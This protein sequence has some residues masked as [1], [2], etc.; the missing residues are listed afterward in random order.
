MR[1]L[2][3]NEQIAQAA[4]EQSHVADDISKN[5]NEITTIAEDSSEHAKQTLEL[6]QELKVM[7]DTLGVQIKKLKA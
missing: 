6:S 4:Q 5:V 2:G 1:I 3:T 7:S